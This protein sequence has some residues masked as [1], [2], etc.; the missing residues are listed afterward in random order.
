MK[1]EA[2]PHLDGNAAAGELNRI[3]AFDITSDEANVLIVG[4]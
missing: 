1:S 2:Y 3:F 4:Q